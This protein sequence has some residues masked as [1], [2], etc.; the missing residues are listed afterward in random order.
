MDNVPDNLLH[1]RAGDAERMRRALR[2]LYDASRAI[3]EVYNVNTVRD[4][5]SALEKAEDYR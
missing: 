4:L 2:D 5:M 1:N 3:V